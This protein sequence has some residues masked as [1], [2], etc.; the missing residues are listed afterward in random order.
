MVQSEDDFDGRWPNH[1][2]KYCSKEAKIFLEEQKEKTICNTSSCTA[3]LVKHV[4]APT[5]AQQEEEIAAK[6]R[7]QVEDKRTEES[8]KTLLEKHAELKEMDAEMDPKER[9]RLEEEI[10]LESVTQN[11]ALHAAVEIA[12]GLQYTESFRTSY[13]SHIRN[14]TEEDFEAYRKRKG[15]SVDGIDCPPPIGSFVEMK[16]PKCILRALKDND[17]HIPTAIQIQG[18]PVA[19]CGRDMIGIASTGSGKT[20]TFALPLIMFCLEQEY[21]MPFERGEGPYALVIVPSRELARQ[22]YDVIVD[23]FQ[24]IERDSNMPKAES[25]TMHWRRS[26]PRASSGLQGVS[27]HGFVSAGVYLPPFLR[28]NRYFSGVHVCVATPGRL[29]DMLTKKI[30]NLEVCRYLVLDEA[31]RMLDMG[32]EDELKSIFAFFKAQRQ[33]LLFSATMP[34]KIQN[35]AKSALVRP[36]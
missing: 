33:T 22:I 21:M 31:D 13:P 25:R 32:F 26:C 35:F 24:A 6:R 34:K 23:L 11:S 28:R 10:L 20:L 7:K 2:K 27:E 17:I 14:Q 9:Q 3:R 12:H 19:L 8:R 1:K 5:S 29:S 36:V 15:I 4:L 16:F 18:I 30:F